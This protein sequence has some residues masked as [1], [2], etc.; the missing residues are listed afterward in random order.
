MTVRPVWKEDTQIKMERERERERKKREKGESSKLKMKLSAPLINWNGK[1]IVG[2][3]LF[4]GFFGGSALTGGG[5]LLASG[6]FSES[7]LMG[8]VGQII[9]APIP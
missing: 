1:F 7:L 3:I 8:P 2:G 4:F 6:S 9:I 5:C